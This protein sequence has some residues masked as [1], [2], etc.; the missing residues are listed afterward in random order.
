M[1]EAF[2][3]L[4]WRCC[5]IC[6]RKVVPCHRCK[7]K[8]LFDLCDLFST[9]GGDCCETIFIEQLGKPGSALIR[10]HQANWLPAA[11]RK[12]AAQSQAYLAARVFLIYP[13]KD[14][15]MKAADIL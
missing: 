5:G 14:H 1:V 2:F 15:L 8:A 13:T 7:P 3:Y 10:I 6:R 11:L 4:V 12:N 9:G